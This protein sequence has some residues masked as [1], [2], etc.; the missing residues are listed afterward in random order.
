MIL[1]YHAIWRLL[2]AQG[3]ACG[4]LPDGFMVQD[5]PI[6][7]FIKSLADKSVIPTLYIQGRCLFYLSNKKASFCVNEEGYP[8]DPEQWL[9]GATRHNDTWW[10]DWT[11]WVGKRAG[12]KISA[13][14]EAGSN[15]YPTIGDAP[16]RYVAE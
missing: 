1:K 8:E 6:Q 5:S 10:N 3:I 14:K 15:Y 11:K 13:P 16:G 12:K 2:F 4:K 7:Q 9:T